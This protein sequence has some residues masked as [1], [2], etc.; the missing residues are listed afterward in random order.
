MTTRTLP[1][2]KTQ[3]FL[4]W[5]F[6][7]AIGG[8]LIG[9]L[10]NNGAQFMATLFL[11]GAIIGSLQWLTFRLM[12]LQGGRWTLWPVASALG[13][14]ASTLLSI[15][16]SMLLVSLTSIVTSSTAE[17]IAWEEFWQNLLMNPSIW[18]WGMAI[19][20]GMI[21]SYHAR[22]R[23]RILGVWLLAS[24]LGAA[25]NG[26]V[27]AILCRSVCQALPSSLIGLVDGKGWAVYGVITG[28]ALLW[29]FRDNSVRLQSPVH[30]PD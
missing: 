11:S 25:L 17:A 5:I 12:H 22:Q 3:L 4:A 1:K 20:Q 7:N 15:L 9:F 13:W 19:A 21:L 28:F 14:I 18:I 29:V 8:F 10:E 27:S 24:C 2:K 23:W 6:A 26:A 16:L 30:R